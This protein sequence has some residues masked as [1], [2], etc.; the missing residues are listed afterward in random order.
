MSSLTQTP[1]VAAPQWRQGAQTSWWEPDSEVVVVAMML[2][3]MTM[4]RR[5]RRGALHHEASTITDTLASSD[6]V[7]SQAISGP[8]KC[9]LEQRVPNKPTGLS[10]WLLFL[11]HI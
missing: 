7:V 11:I 5:S 2:M 4:K 6:A 8:V 10:L 9:E 1:G 3:M